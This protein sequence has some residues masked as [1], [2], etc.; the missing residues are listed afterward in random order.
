M[1]R[2]TAALSSTHPRT[3]R[4]PLTLLQGFGRRL[5]P[6]FWRLLKVLLLGRISLGLPLSR[7]LSLSTLSLVALL[8]NHARGVCNLDS[9]IHDDAVLSVA[10]IA[11]TRHVQAHGKVCATKCGVTWLT[12]LLVVLLVATF[13]AV[14]GIKPNGSRPVAHTRLM[15][16]ARF[17]L[18]VMVLI[19]AY[20][21]FRAR[22]G[23]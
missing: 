3:L 21:A 5:V 2:A 10:S 8:L 14:T 20:M 23:G 6:A 18:V 4:T 12:W 15:G 13:A 22:S 17:V 9:H 19:V 7:T 11:S 1:N 16:V